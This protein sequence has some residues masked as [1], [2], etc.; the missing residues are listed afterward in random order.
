MI[1]LLFEK[2]ESCKFRA[3]RKA[4]FGKDILYCGVWKK[5][6]DRTIY[7]AV[8]YDGK[9]KYAFVKRFSITSITR[10]KEYPLA[11]IERNSKLLYLSVN[12][13]GEAETIK[14]L[15]RPVPKLKRVKFEFD[16]SELAIKGRAAKGNVLTKHI[17]HKIEMKE[18]GVST[19]AALKV[20]WDETVQRLNY[21]GRGKYI[22]AFAGD[23]KIVTIH[24]DGH[25]KLSPFA[26]TTKFDEDIILMQKYDA[27]KVYSMIYWEAEKKYFYVKRFNL[28]PTDKKQSLVGEFEGSYIEM[29]TSDSEPR[30]FV[31]YDKRGGDRAD[32]LISI[33]HFIAVKGQKALGNRLTPYKVKSINVLEPILPTDPPPP[34]AEISSGPPSLPSSK[35]KDDFPPEGPIQITLEL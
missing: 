10:D 6:D 3:S 9:S 26:D 28:E 11:G 7:N 24:R 32:D 21:E 8:Y 31:Q 2:T 14:V 20:Y 5:G 33:V 4:F 23:D 13:N 27:Q 15:L 12:P 35:P 17:I 19:L 30:V 18:G 34:Q 16:F 25:Y 22:G 1:L 29:I